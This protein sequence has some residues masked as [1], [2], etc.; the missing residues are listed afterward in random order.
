M[1][2]KVLFEKLHVISET[3]R[4][5]RGFWTIPLIHMA[6]VACTLFG[7]HPALAQS[8]DAKI[9][10][11]QAIRVD[12][13]DADT[14][15]N[16]FKLRLVH[17]TRKELALLSKTWMEMTQAETK[18]AAEINIQLSSSSRAD[19]KGLRAQLGAALKRR[20]L[21]FSKFGLILEAWS[22]K[23]AEA[24]E[25]GNYQRYMAAVRLS[26]FQATDAETLSKW[27]LEWLSSPEGGV[28]IGIL[29]LSFVAMLIAAS[30]F[31]RIVTSLL[32]RT[33]RRVPKMSNLLRDFIA[34]L[35]YW[36]ALG[37]GVLISLSLFGINITPLL[38]VFGGASFIIGFAMQSTLSN[39]ASGLLI[40]ITKPFDVGDVVE[41]A[42][43]SG[44]IQAI[45]IVSTTIVSFDN[46]S[47]V[48]PNTKV[49][50]SVIT[51]VNRN[52]IRRIDLTF[53]ISYEDDI[54]VARHTLS[55]VINAHALTLAEPAPVI[56][57]NELADSSVNIVCRPWVRTE[58]YWV[59]YWGLQQLIKEA[60]DEAGVSIPYPQRD[61]H[62][63]PSGGVPANIHPVQS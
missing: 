11:E 12:P 13:P 60:F 37:L 5:G 14:K 17:L 16:I 35:S 55:Q 1:S 22:A 21:L 50:D 18:R 30:F 53:G 43:V 39:L 23:G 32:N 63:R 59:A 7:Y 38:A 33:L 45:S 27:F 10:S 40:M 24:K 47:I 58:D 28:R 56:A 2:M 31:A 61:V 62:I 49:W 26:E 6:I 51:N 8:S 20:N 25:L 44:T 29:L 9:D 46:Q 36:L 4:K 15:D 41:A 52:E 3:G 48:V 42:G 34:G 54:D 19:A 57:V